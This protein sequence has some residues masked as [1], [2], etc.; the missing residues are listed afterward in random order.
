MILPLKE[1]VGLINGFVSGT[2]VKEDDET[3]LWALADRERALDAAAADVLGE[4]VPAGCLCR[5]LRLC[6]TVSS[7]CCDGKEANELDL[8]SASAGEAEREGNFLVSFF[9]LSLVFRSPVPADL[10]FEPVVETAAA[11][12][13]EFFATG[14]DDE[15]LVFF[16]L[17]FLCFRPEE[18]VDDEEPEEE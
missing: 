18:D 11:L 3:R 5:E 12:P 16:F 7:R 9:G 4:D 14:R 8:L 2:G 17:L 1:D 15:V 6:S 10:F 13:V